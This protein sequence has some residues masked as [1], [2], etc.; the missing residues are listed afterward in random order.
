MNLTI[1]IKFQCHRNI[2]NE[3]EKKK[4]NLKLQ[5]VSF[6]TRN[7]CLY[8][9]DNNNNKNIVVF[10]RAHTWNYLYFEN[11][12]VISVLLAIL[13]KT[14]Y[15][16]SDNA[17]FIWNY[18]LVCCWC[19]FCVCDYLLSWFENMSQF[20]ID[21]LSRHFYCSQLVLKFQPLRSNLCN[22]W[23]RCIVCKINIRIVVPSV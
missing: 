6:S 5:K 18:F 7:E 17:Y 14:S 10:K 13:K 9:C 1:K 22:K 2:F 19:F 11:F 15:R 4:N 8:L 21:F 12:K 23:E 3:I 16:N 20:A